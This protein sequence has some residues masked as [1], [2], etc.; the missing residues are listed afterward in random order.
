MI[1]GVMQW[2][3]FHAIFDFLDHE[4]EAF[5]DNILYGMLSMVGAV[6]ATLLIFWIF[7]QGYQIMTGR[8]RDSAM[9]LV[10]NSLRSVLVVSVAMSVA[11]GG[12]DLYQAFTDDMPK[13]IMQI[14]TGSNDAPADEIDKSLDQMQ[15]AFLGIDGLATKG[16]LG[17]K[18]DK[19][20]ALMLTA[21]GIAGPSVVGGAMLL[22]YKIAMALFVG[23]GPLFILCLLFD[24]TKQLFSKWLYYGI[25]T[26]FSLA[27]LSFMVAVAMKMVFAVAETFAAQYAI[28]LAL[29]LD[30]Q[31]ANS[32]ALQQGGLGLILTVLLVM[33]PPMAAQFFQGTLGSFSAYSQFGVTGGRPQMDASGKQVGFTPQPMNTGRTAG[34]QDSVG[35]QMPSTGSNAAMAGVSTPNSYAPQPDTVKTV[36]NAPGRD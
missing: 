23:L 31:S 14:V 19:D 26:M 12:V 30:P 34:D 25:G 24:Q 27:V 7:W 13:G 3:F 22:L 4:V 15:L 16:D 20:R 18:D 5:R 9:A 36:S 11:F 21:V 2:A 28:G 10:T 8:S 35:R 6:A 33:T 29:G 32:M 17:L 1:D